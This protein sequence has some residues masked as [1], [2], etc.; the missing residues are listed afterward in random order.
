LCLFVALA[1]ILVVLGCTNLGPA[2]ERGG[3]P[4]HPKPPEGKTTATPRPF[5]LALQEGT[6]PS[7]DAADLTAHVAALT[8]PRTAGRRAGSDG[9][10]IA[11]DYLE[12]SFAALGLEPGAGAAGSRHTFSFTSGVSIGPDNELTL[13][14]RNEGPIP[15]V[16]EEDWRPLAFSQ[17]GVIPK[18][19]IAFVGYGLVASESPVDQAID[20]Y[21]ELDVRDRWVLVFRGL[22]HSLDPERRQRLQRHAS[23][24]YKAMLARDH[25]A[26]G[27]LFVSGPRGRFRE[28]L[29]PLRFD[30]SLAGTRI[31]VL[32]IR[33]EVAGR[34]LE[35][36][37]RSLDEIQ[38]A[39]DAKLTGES[40]AITPLESPIELSEV[41]LEGRIDLETRLAEGTNVLARLQLGDEPSPEMIVLGAHFDHLGHGEGSSSLASG[42]E[43]GA[44][45]PGADD[46]ASGA[47]LL[48]EIAEFLAHRRST[49]ANLGQ[50]DFLFAAWSG[51]ELGLLGSD[52]WVR[53]TIT[54]HMTDSIPVAYLNFDMVGR[55]DEELIVQG[56][57][58]SPAWTEI[59]DRAETSASLD[60]SISRQQDSYIPT[61]ATS[62]Y[63]QGIPVLSAFTGVHS[64]YH[65]PRDTL[66][67]LNLAGT[68]RIGA[69]FAEIAVD[70]SRAE[71]GPPYHA[72]QA[73]SAG[74]GLRGFRV[75][76]GTLPDY[77]QTDIVGVRLTGVAPGGPAEKGGIRGGDVIVEVDGRPIE[78]LYDYTFALEALRVG[79]KARIGV[80]RGGDR[81]D[82]EVVPTSRD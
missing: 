41:V 53:E 8:D 49:G 73:P 14:E 4:P 60:L 1:V 27:I 32:S 48:I 31:A 70:L 65:T 57:G 81:V 11:A 29:I 17:S 74:Q 55:L 2:P 20:D 36:T 45:H 56:L 15:L 58:S 76:L 34:L 13:S 6:R 50:R 47:A 38:Q 64:E 28:E 35:E 33:D 26:R 51:E 78:N 30:A 43:V 52:A 61:D 79:E 24:R 23:L 21:A 19:E 25:G 63:T 42:G 69:L 22:P 40:T 16:V 5:P 3:M 9:E 44:I 54:P 12:R 80:L 59:L 39:T 77:A 82:L 67:R 37:G 75:F 71:S 68:T 46:N 72:Q 7:I 66:E 10:R 18:S 62:F